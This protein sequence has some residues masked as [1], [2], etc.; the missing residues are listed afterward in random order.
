MCIRDRYQR[1]VHGDQIKLILIYI[2]LRY[3]IKFLTEN[4]MKTQTFFKL[5]F[6]VLLLIQIEQFN[7]DQRTQMRSI[8]FE[9]QTQIGTSVT[10][11]TSKISIAAGADTFDTMPSVAKYGKGYIAVY[12]NS[13]SIIAV[14][15]SSLTAVKGTELAIYTAT[16]GYVAS[17][18]SIALLSTSGYIICYQ[19]CYTTTG[20]VTYT[21][22]VQCI[23]LKS[24][25]T[26]EGNVKTLITGSAVATQIPF[27]PSVYGL[28]TG[29]KFVVL[30]NTQA[31]LLAYVRT[32]STLASDT[33][34]YT[35]ASGTLGADL[36]QMVEFPYLGVQYVAIVYLNGL[37][38]IGLIQI[39]V[40]SFSGSYTTTTVTSGG[41]TNDLFLSPS[42]QYLVNGQLLITM[43]QYDSS[44]SSYKVYSATFSPRFYQSNNNFLYTSWVQLTSAY[45][46]CQ[47]T[48]SIVLQNDEVLVSTGCL[49][50]GTRVLYSILLD[51]NGIS[52]LD[53][54]VLETSQT[55]GT[56]YKKPSSVLLSDDVAL[57]AFE[58]TSTEKVYGFTF[59]KISTY[60]N[61]G[62]TTTSSAQN[63]IVCLAS[64]VFAMLILIML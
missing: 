48:S 43:I 15:Y 39:P 26:L 47:T 23:R 52:I 60:K 37:Q 49:V 42:I 10:L 5:T 61:L 35:L 24:D 36:A 4:K 2:Y 28:S 38:S 16:T 32:Y 12:V 62:D 6:A 58:E 27:F 63:L 33:S 9:R 34:T 7:F 1:R 29:D 18:P 51:S 19:V 40:D 55:A 13:G 3:Q 22:S 45:T 14:P 59:T 50:S 25:F 56:L 20:T 30:V 64:L 46:D 11:S 57:V 17:Y 8:N 41:D 54:Q 31:N 21:Y 44:A 53:K